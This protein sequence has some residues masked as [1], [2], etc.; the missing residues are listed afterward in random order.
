MNRLRFLGAS[1]LAMALTLSLV[2]SAFA[3]S[4]PGKNRIIC[5]PDSS[6]ATASGAQGCVFDVGVGENAYA[7]YGTSTGG[8]FPNAWDKNLGNIAQLSFRYSGD[9]PYGGVPRF[10]I[11]IDEDGTGPLVPGQK[12]PDPPPAPNQE[13]YV[14]IGAEDCN[15]G[16]GLVDVINDSTCTVYYGGDLY[17]NWDAFSAA[18]P[19]ATLYFAF[20]IADAPW[21]GTISSLKIGKPG[22]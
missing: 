1:L 7:Y 2:A 15:N 8:Y 19:D 16:A 10:S 6:T 20:V 13:T 9:L 12:F 21:S 14:F 5:G 22:K 17:A 4:P 18:Y 11:L 3:A